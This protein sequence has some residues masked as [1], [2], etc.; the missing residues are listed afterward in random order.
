MS[1][2][3]SIPL[4]K[5]VAWDGNV[6]KTAGA[7]TS[8]HELASSI[9]AHGLINN[10]VVKPHKKDTHAVIAGG[11]RLAALQLLAK[12]GTLPADHPVKCEILGDKA[13]ALELSLAEN[14]VREQ[15]HP[16]DEFDAFRVLIDDGMPTADI[17]ARF[18]VTETVVLQRLK[19]ARVSPVIIQAYREGAIDLECVMAFAVVDDHKRQKHFW[20]TAPEWAKEQPRQI[21]DALTEGEIDAAGRRVRFVTLKAYEK[22]GGTIRRDLFAAGDHGVFI[23]DVAL[24]NTLAADKLPLRAPFVPAS[25]P[26]FGYVRCYTASRH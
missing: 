10:L 17:A 14:A 18:G 11:R 9:A 8:L 4:N 7:D 15:M 23:G 13:N 2:V 1:D 3:T 21:R 16:A 6:R 26:S 22:A 19:L 25:L 20:K 12:A 24:L 5:L